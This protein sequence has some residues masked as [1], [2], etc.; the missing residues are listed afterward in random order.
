MK[1]YVSAK[2]KFRCSFRSLGLRRLVL[3]AK[4]LQELVIGLPKLQA[5]QSIPRV[6]RQLNRREFSDAL[7]HGLGTHR[8]ICP[9]SS[10]DCPHY[11]LGTPVAVRTTQRIWK[12][13]CWNHENAPFHRENPRSFLRKGRKGPVARP[14]RRL[15]PCSPQVGAAVYPP[16][17]DRACGSVAAFRSERD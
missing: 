6:G 16:C 14:S 9:Y 3:V 10:M 12:T 2:L 4:L 7:R 5:V 1:I 17:V 13:W 15:T 11:G 8:I